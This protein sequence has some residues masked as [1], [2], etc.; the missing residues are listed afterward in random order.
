MDLREV[1]RERHFAAQK[2]ALQREKRERERERKRRERERARERTLFTDG[3]FSPLLFLSAITA[4]NYP[5]H[6]RRNIPFSRVRG[7][8]KM[9]SLGNLHHEDEEEEEEPP[10]PMNASLWPSSNTNN[11][12]NNKIGSR[13]NAKERS[14]AKKN[15]QN[16]SNN[17]GMSTFDFDVDV[18]GD[19]D[20]LDGFL[21]VE[22]DE[23]EEENE[24]QNA[25]QAWGVG[26]GAAWKTE[27]IK[28]TGG[29][30]G[31]KR[32]RDVATASSAEK[33]KKKNAASN[34]DDESGENNNNNNN[35]GKSS[36]SNTNNNNNNNNNNADSDRCRLRWTPELHARFLRSVKTLGGLDIATPKGVVELMRVQ[37]VTIQHVKS[38]LQKYRLQE[39]QMSKATSNARSKALSIGER[40]FLTSTF[41][42]L[43]PIIAN[44]EKVI[45]KVASIMNN[46]RPGA[47]TSPPNAT[48]NKNTSSSPEGTENNTGNR[49]STPGGDNSDGTIMLGVPPLDEEEKR[50]HIKAAR[51][52]VSA[53]RKRDKGLRFP[54]EDVNTSAE[55][56]KLAAVNKKLILTNDVP[57]D[58]N[59]ENN[60]DTDDE[61][62]FTAALPHISSP[63]KAP[64]MMKSALGGVGGGAKLPE[65]VS[66]VLLRQIEMQKQLHEQLL[67]QRKLQ[68]AIEEHGKYL[69][70]IMEESATEKTSK[71]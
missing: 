58:D 35:N 61:D 30:S 21:R 12:N 11:N 54:D 3:S 67:K 23:D 19:L 45:A 38:H 34:D 49:N 25:D 9:F 70:K 40:S 24:N 57:R 63:L 48:A 56:A 65:D 37:G 15:N 4:R 66:A 27:A 32:G 50:R 59:F 44:E 52:A 69:Q 7:K 31:V 36:T 64:M 22:D 26:K 17:N 2:R 55:L 10:T 14:G 42:G 33:K 47:T 8:Q 62:V 43:P 51:M 1:F 60:N 18:P 5:P 53:K 71:S 20:W 16:Q 29:K 46:Q 68:T 13:E 39:Q 28:T 6:G 41:V